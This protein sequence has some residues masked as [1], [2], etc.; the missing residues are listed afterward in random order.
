MHDLQPN[1]TLFFIPNLAQNTANMG[2]G[3]VLT[4]L[5]QGIANF[6]ILKIVSMK[7]CEHPTLSTLLSLLKINVLG[8]DDKLL[9]GIHIFDSSTQ[10][11]VLAPTRTKPTLDTTL[12]PT[13][14]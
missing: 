11:V 1:L 8:I 2:P 12:S 7:F 5:P 3:R 9:C 13:S 4:N 10:C 6:F 14:T